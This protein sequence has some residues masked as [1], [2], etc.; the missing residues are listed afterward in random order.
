MKLIGTACGGCP[1][2]RRAVAIARAVQDIAE[3]GDGLLFMQSRRRVWTP[4]RP[5]YFRSLSDRALEQPP[6]ASSTLFGRELPPDRIRERILTGA[7]VIA[8]RDLEGRPLDANAREA[9]KRSTLDAYFEEC[10]SRTVTQ[11][12]ITVYARPG[13]C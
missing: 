8:V 13:H 6:V 9:V 5:G 7:R 10:A 11:A 1:S 12:R 2:T 4:A 3:P